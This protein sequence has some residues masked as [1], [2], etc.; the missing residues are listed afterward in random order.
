MPVLAQEAWRGMEEGL[1]IT[2]VFTR[3][4]GEGLPRDAHPELR[5]PEPPLG[6]EQGCAAAGAGVPGGPE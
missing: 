5:A 1:T 6:P 3:R 2:I 4:C